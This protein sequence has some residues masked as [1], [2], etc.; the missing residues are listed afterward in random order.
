M[1][2]A[3]CNNSADIKTASRGLIKETRGQLICFV[4]NSHS[5]QHAVNTGMST[6]C[7]KCRCNKK[8]TYN[9]NPAP[10]PSSAVV[11]ELIRL[12]YLGLD[13]HTH[14]FNGPFSGT[15]E[16]SR[17]QKGKPIW[18]LLKQETVSASGIRWAKSAPRSRQ[19]TTPASHHS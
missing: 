15:T 2:F 5:L 13:T 12:V 19:T 7:S 11:V 3:C 4:L 9:F 17:Y 6:N 18:I 10:L 8:A 14:P 16:V 1:C